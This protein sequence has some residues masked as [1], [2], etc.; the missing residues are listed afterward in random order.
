MKLWHSGELE[1][2]SCPLCGPEAERK[3][4]Y[5]FG[6]FQVVTCGTCGL[7]YLTPRLAEKEI[8]RLYRDQDYFISSVSG[9]GYDEY[10]DVRQNW[11]K[12]FR[13]RLR[14]IGRYKPSGRVLDV[15]CG[16]GF[17][18]EAALEMGY[19][20]FG[21]DPSDYIV[22]RAQDEL[23]QRIYKGT[24]ETVDFDPQ[25]FDLIVVFDTFEIFTIHC[26]GWKQS[27]GCSS[28]REY[29]LSPHPILRAYFHDCPEK[30]GSPSRSL[31]MSFTGPPKPSRWPWR[32]I[33]R[34]WRFFAPG[35][36]PRLVS[37]FGGCSNYPK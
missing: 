28:Q 36:M 20:A 23:G 14:Q 26:G 34:C 10:L 12:T 16:P 29:W 27:I 8:I 31:N 3:S 6:P 21:L 37:C 35:N 25:L 9:Q 15:G 2:A 22:Q 7:M 33:F 1:S 11:I 32:R 24:L 19:D 13:L 30:G 4:R 17:F 5:T 18:L